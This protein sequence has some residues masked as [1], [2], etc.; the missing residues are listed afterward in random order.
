METSFEFVAAVGLLDI[1]PYMEMAQIMGD[2]RISPNT[3]VVS[4][5]GR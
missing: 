4:Q 1:Y 2:S 3:F 5:W